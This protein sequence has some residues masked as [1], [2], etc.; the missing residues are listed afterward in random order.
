MHSALATQ[1]Q[2]EVFKKPEPGVHKI[3]L[4]TNIAETSLTTDD[5][6]FVVDC[7]KMKEKGFDSNKNMESLEMVWVSRANA[8][9]RKEHARR[10][11]PGVCIHLFTR[12]RYDYQVPRASLS[13]NYIVC[14]WNI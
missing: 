5:C 2:A 3:I 4:S 11:M 14:F 1:E 12:Y 7:C 10:V 8:L 13:Q 9:Q 6:V